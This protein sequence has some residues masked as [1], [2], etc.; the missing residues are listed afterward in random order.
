M[1]RPQT[2][3]KLLVLDIIFVFKEKWNIP[4]QWIFGNPFLKERKLC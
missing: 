1:P 3:I 4:I 2:E